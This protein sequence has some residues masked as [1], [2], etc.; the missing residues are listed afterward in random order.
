L[1]VVRYGCERIPRQQEI[2]PQVEERLGLHLEIWL[3]LLRIRHSIS[4]TG[5][6]HSPTISTPAYTMSKPLPQKQRYRSIVRDLC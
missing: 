3:I 4:L 6:L 2:A 1:T 5:A